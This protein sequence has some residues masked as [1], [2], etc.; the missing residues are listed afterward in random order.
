V[1]TLPRPFGSVGLAEQENRLRSPAPNQCR[2]TLLEVARD[3]KH[4]GAEIGFF[5]V[6]HTWSQKLELHPH[7]HCVVP[8]GGLSVDHTGGPEHV[9]RYLSRYTHRVAG[10]SAFWPTGG[11]P[12]FCR[13]A[14]SCW[15]QPKSRKPDNTLLPLKTRL[16]FGAVPSVAAQ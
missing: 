8:D 5:S 16:V 13:F 2:N 14:F 10:I 15:A 6:L 1:F 3:P 4:L 9:L 7:V 11:V 12:R